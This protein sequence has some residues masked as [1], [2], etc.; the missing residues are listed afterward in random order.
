M[1]YT[2]DHNSKLGLALIAREDLSDAQYVALEDA[3]EQRRAIDHAYLRQLHAVANGVAEGLVVR[4][5]YTFV[6]ADWEILS[7]K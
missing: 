4:Q 5:R 7:K 1:F 6:P 2:Y 3:P